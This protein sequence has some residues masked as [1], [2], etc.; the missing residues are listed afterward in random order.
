M[1][2]LKH[3]YIKRVN[4]Y[5]SKTPPWLS[6]LLQ[7]FFTTFVICLVV[8]VIFSYIYIYVPVKGESMYPTLNNLETSD[9]V[10]INR[11]NKGDRG[12]IIVAENPEPF[13]S[14]DK[15]IIKRVI[16]T[17]GDKLAIYEESPPRGGGT[18]K[19]QIFL[20]KK[21][22]DNRVVVSEPYL[23]AR[24]DMSKTFQRFYDKRT[25]IG[26][27]PFVTVND[28]IVGNIQYLVIPDDCVFYLGDNRS[29]SNDCSKFGYVKSETIVGRV[30]IIVK[31][32]KN[33]FYFIIS[34][35]FQL[36]FS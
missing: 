15:Y 32:S 9:S 26:F 13:N 25:Y 30:D 36:I 11:I 31:E 23:D 18:G 7:A 33:N 35:L 29:N 21:G 24:V 16:A 22:T 6:A 20:I 12:D 8:S 5:K 28:S 14:E 10:Y 19:Y 4:I 1:T 3:G 17:G 2:E 34:S 27:D